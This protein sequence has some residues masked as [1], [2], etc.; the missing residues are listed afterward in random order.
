MQVVY[1]RC[2]GIDV[3]KRM[4]VGCL[5]V[6]E[7]DGQERKDTRTFGTT[8]VEILRLVDWL[9]SEECRIVVMESTSVYWKP[10]FNLL[11]GIIEVWIVNAQHIRAV[12]GCKTDVRDAHWLAQLLQHGLLHPS[13]IPP[14]PQRELRDLTRS[15]TSLSADRA[16]VV[17]RIQ[18][19][20][21]DGNIKL[22]SVAA[23]IL[24]KS[25]RA[26]LTA[27]VAGETDLAA[28][29]GLAQ[30][31]MQSKQPQPVEALDGHLTEHHRFLL[32]QLFAQ[33]DFLDT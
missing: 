9:T 4:I 18:K 26:M 21:E 27:L 16:R 12:S 17:N 3:H 32:R 15:R 11:E 5:L 29:A 20:L 24:S 8:T 25:G 7:K 31:R 10:I 13:F 22:S 6:M 30:K 19:V 14:A 1:M 28:I 33:V 2:C 23:D